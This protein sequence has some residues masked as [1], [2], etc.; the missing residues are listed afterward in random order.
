[1]L[2]NTCFGAAPLECTVSIGAIY[3][4]FV[5][6]MLAAAVLMAC[7]LGV[8]VIAFAGLASGGT[9]SRGS[10]AMLFAMVIGIYVAALLF[11][12]LI[13]PYVQARTANAV[14]SSTS[15]GTHAF[16]SRLPVGGYI[17]LFLVNWLGIIFTLGLFVPWARVR[18]AR[19]RAQ[20]LALTVAGSLDDFVAA[21][22]VAASA[23]G[24]QTAEMFDLDIGL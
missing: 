10:A 11:Q 14:W 24:D 13:I 20:H 4:I 2:N 1:M 9:L 21:E 3:R 8:G 19:Y 18:V 5:L 16:I 6:P 17:G 7:I 15:L 23:L 12:A 22:A